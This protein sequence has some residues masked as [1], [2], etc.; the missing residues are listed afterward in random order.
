MLPSWSGL[1]VLDLEF[2]DAAR[3]VATQR[4]R[5]YEPGTTRQTVQAAGVW[6]QTTKTVPKEFERSMRRE[7]PHFVSALLEIR[8]WHA[9][10]D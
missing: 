3:R 4:Y 5:R 7:H 6:W 9:F 2:I 10:R 8:I 1:I